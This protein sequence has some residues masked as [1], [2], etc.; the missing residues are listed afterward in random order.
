MISY[1]S[2]CR[3][4]DI[5]DQ[6]C[7]PF[8][9]Q[10]HYVRY[11]KAPAGIDILFQALQVVTVIFLVETY[12]Q[13]SCHASANPPKAKSVTCLVIS[14]FAQEFKHL[15]LCTCAFRL[16]HITMFCVC[17]ISLLMLR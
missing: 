9:S 11:G 1:V 3:F 17:S 2:S 5:F 10:K 16:Y 13:V 12:L 7:C 4:F 14:Y 8:A 15:I 6:R